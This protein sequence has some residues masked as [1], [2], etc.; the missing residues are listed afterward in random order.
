MAAVHWRTEDEARRRRHALTG[1]RAYLNP[2]EEGP[3]AI[4]FAAGAIVGAL[5]AVLTASGLAACGLIR[6]GGL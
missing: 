1:Q 5:V 2:L 3:G 6:I 4:T